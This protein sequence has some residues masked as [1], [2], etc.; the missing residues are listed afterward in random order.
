MIL[1]VW[2]VDRPSRHMRPWALLV[3]LRS[4]WHGGWQG[5]AMHFWDSVYVDNS[6]LI[7]S[8][9]IWIWTFIFHQE[10]VATCCKMP[11]ISSSFHHFFVASKNGEKSPSKMLFRDHRQQLQL[12]R[13]TESLEEICRPGFTWKE[14]CPPRKLTASLHLKKDGKGRQ[15]LPFFLGAKA[16]PIFRGELAVS[17]G[18]VHR[19]V[20]YSIFLIWIYIHSSKSTQPFDFYWVSDG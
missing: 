1:Q 8:C 6:L 19:R 2:G 11:W 17:W 4:K 20:I 16:G 18:G 7:I 12:G 13:T 14:G 3:V 10:Y 9:Y 15:A 5:G